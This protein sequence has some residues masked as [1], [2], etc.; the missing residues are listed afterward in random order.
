M[1]LHMNGWWRTC[2]CSQKNQD[3]NTTCPFL[4]LADFPVIHRLVNLCWVCAHFHC[5]CAFPSFAMNFDFARKSLRLLDSGNCILLDFGAN[6]QLLDNW[7]S[8]TAWYPHLGRYDLSWC[9]FNLHVVSQNM[10][11]MLFPLDVGWSPMAKKTSPCSL[12]WS[13]STKNKTGDYTLRCHQTWPAG[14]SEYPALAACW[15]TGACWLNIFEI[16]LL[17]HILMYHHLVGNV[18]IYI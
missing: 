14:K 1:F 5:L 6:S 17:T 18:S 7:L 8:F 2:L 11:N 13:I 15:L 9:V 16:Y 4:F 12:H 10:S 3:L